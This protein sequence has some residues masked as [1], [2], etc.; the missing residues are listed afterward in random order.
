[1]GDFVILIDSS[2]RLIHYLS[3]S[4]TISR[5]ALKVTAQI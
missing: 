4:A 2:L 1:M 5:Q 3:H